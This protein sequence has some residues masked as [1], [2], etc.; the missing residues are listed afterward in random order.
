MSVRIAVPEFAAEVLRRRIALLGPDQI[1]R[2][3]FASRNG[4]AL[5]PSNVRRTFRDFLKP[6]RPRRP[7]HQLAPV[8]PHRRNGLRPRHEQGC[9]PL[10]LGRT[11]SATTEGHYIEPDPTIDPTPAAH[12]DRTLRPDRPDCSL[13]AMIPNPGGGQLGRAR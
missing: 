5:S 8:P 13:L 2:T 10:F 3:I 4:G 11:N 7:W 9:G 1:D 12:L 6:R